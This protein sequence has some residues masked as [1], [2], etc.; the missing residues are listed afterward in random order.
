MNN[1][2]DLS[3]DL[4][5]NKVTGDIALKRGEEALKQHI[6]L[7]LLC[8]P[9]A[10]IGRPFVC[11]GLRDFIKEVSDSALEE[12]VKARIRNSL[13]YETRVIA[14]DIDVRFNPDEKVLHITIR[15]EYVNSDKS[16]TYTTRLRRIL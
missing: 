12:E 3:A 8:S 6:D 1:V 4:K 2:S 9:Y 16:F 7:L 15:F 13:K 11:A 10:A 14:T 5:R